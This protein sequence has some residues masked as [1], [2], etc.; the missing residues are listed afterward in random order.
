MVSVLILLKIQFSCTFQNMRFYQILGDFE[1]YF[2]KI[3]SLFFFW[4]V[5]SSVMSHIFTFFSLLQ[6]VRIC[7]L[8]NFLQTLRL[9]ARHLKGPSNLFLCAST[10]IVTVRLIS[11]IIW[12]VKWKIWDFEKMKPKIEVEYFN[13]ILCFELLKLFSKDS[14]KHFYG[15]RIMFKISERYALPSSLRQW[16]MELDAHDTWS[17]E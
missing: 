8:E 6:R 10:K 11:R 15:I 17:S 14:V 2:F 3:S 13:K 12:Q 5:I 7:S 16:I 1:F 4:R 9:Y